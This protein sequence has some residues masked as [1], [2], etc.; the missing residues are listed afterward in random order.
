MAIYTQD[1]LVYPANIINIDGN[2]CTIRYLHYLNE[3][4]KQLDELFEHSEGEKIEK[5]ESKSQY[6]AQKQPFSSSVFL[7]PPPPMPIPTVPGASSNVTEDEAL[8]S[9][10]IS[11]YMS[12]YHT[13]FYYGLKS[14]RSESK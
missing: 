13:G 7:P 5:I 8:H 1:G 10:L 4:D 3:E 6:H 11:W 9:M 14:S 2:K 12:G